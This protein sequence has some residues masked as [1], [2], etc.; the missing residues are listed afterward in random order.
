MHC[1]SCSKEYRRA[2]F[3]RDETFFECDDCEVELALSPEE[4]AAL[5][6]DA[7]PHVEVHDL[8]HHLTSD[9]A[10]PARSFVPLYLWIGLLSLNLLGGLAFGVATVLAGSWPLA[11]V[12]V[13][14]YFAI[15]G[16]PIIGLVLRRSF[17]VYITYVYFGIIFLSLPLSILRSFSGSMAEGIGS[18]CGTGIWGFIAYRWVRWFYHNRHEFGVAVVEPKLHTDIYS[19]SNV[20]RS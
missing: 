13:V 17:G 10:A 1:P 5:V 2:D 18:V 15:F 19:E 14:V 12:V 3:G 8:S 4:R 9:G 6:A 11:L 7:P 16:T 20:T